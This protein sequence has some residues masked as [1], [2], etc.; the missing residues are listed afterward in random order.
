VGVHMKRGDDAMRG[1]RQ[2]VL[3]LVGSGSAR[4]AAGSCGLD[5][6][7]SP[8]SSLHSGGSELRQQRGQ[9]MIACRPRL[10]PPPLLP[11]PFAPS[12][13][14]DSSTIGG[15]GRRSA[16]DDQ[17]PTHPR[18]GGGGQP[19]RPRLFPLSLPGV[20]PLGEGQAWQ[21]LLVPTTSTHLGVDSLLKALL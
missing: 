11:S 20:K 18:W 7:L 14:G 12:A 6:F 10:R 15:S 13:R 8:P 4:G 1:R 9:Q 16:G 17:W 3:G 21:F 5:N 19:V 2:R